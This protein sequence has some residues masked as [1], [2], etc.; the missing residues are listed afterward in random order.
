M[1]RLVTKL[2][3]LNGITS[4]EGSHRIGGRLAPS[5]C[6]RSDIRTPRSRNRTPR[7]PVAASRR[8]RRKSRLLEILM[9]AG[10]EWTAEV[11]LYVL[12]KHD[13]VLAGRMRPVRF[14]IHPRFENRKMV[15]CVDLPKDDI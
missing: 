5:F 7:P 11:T 8:A 10:V 6:S 14:R 12:A 9:Y 2:A 3:P 15:S 4:S 1:S 13:R